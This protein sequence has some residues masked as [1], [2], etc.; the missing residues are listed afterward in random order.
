MAAHVGDDRYAAGQT[1]LAHVG[2][3]REVQAE[4]G[5]C[6]VCQF[7]GM[8]EGDLEALGRSFERRP[9][10]VGSGGDKLCH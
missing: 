4:A 2:V 5:S 8:D 6:H 9:G 7:R 10:R 3:P 1:D